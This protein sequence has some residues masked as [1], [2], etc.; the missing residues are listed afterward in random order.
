MSRS[1]PHFAEIEGPTATNVETPQRRRFEYEIDMSLRLVNGELVRPAKHRKELCYVA[2]E[3]PERACR[4]MDK[5][6]GALEKFTNLQERAQACAFCMA[7]DIGTMQ[8]SE[9][10]E[11]V[12]ALHVMSDEC[13][14]K[15]RVWNN[16]RKQV[17]GAALDQ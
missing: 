9:P 11:F 10:E 12:A 14:E 13:V 8:E 3:A 16:A 6:W 5:I 4:I 15:I 7:A 1:S 2:G 17:S